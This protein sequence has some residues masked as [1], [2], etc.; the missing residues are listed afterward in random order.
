MPLRSEHLLSGVGAGQ[1]LAQSVRNPLEE[2]LGHDL[3]NVRVHD[4]TEVGHS[5][6][7][8]GAQA[9]T[10]GN[11]I[12]FASGQFAPETSQGRRLLAHELAHVVQQTGSPEIA[13]LSPAKAGGMQRNG[14]VNAWQADL[15]QRKA[16]VKSLAKQGDAT[17]S[18]GVDPASGKASGFNLTQNFDLELDSSAIASD[19]A[20][21]QWIK[22]ELFELRGKDKVYWPASMGLH[23]RKNT[24]PFYFADWVVDT[25]DADPRFGS[26]YGLK[27]M[28]PVTRIEDSPGVL[29]QGVLPAGLTYDISA[30]MGV[31]PWG[32]RVPTDISGWE[33]QKPEPF[34]EVDWGWKITVAPDQ[35]RFDVTVK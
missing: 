16:K 29:T 5:A 23:G 24:A 11:D 2:R 25:P 21:V 20:V 1:S 14:M 26:H 4:E 15:A 12:V 22:G 34:M 30:R 17:F 10:L 32:S 31:Y 9:Y 13:G 28:V 35:K 8:M 19:Y 33:S 7:A 3:A 6:T 27:V 18:Y